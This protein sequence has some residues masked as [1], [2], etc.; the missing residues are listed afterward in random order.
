MNKLQAIVLVMMLFFAL[1]SCKTSKQ[2]AGK[3]K[4]DTTAAAKTQDTSAVKKPDVATADKQKLIDSLTPLWNKQIEYNTFA[5]KARMHYEAGGDK[6]DF[7]ANIRIQKDKIIWVSATALGGIVQVARI[8]ITPDSFKLINYLQKT[9]TLMTLQQAQALLPTPMDFGVLQ[10]LLVGNVLSKENKIIN[11]MSTPGLWTLQA[12]NA[13]FIQ[14]VTYNKA[15]TTIRSEQL[16]D[17]KPGGPQATIQYNNYV[18]VDNR[19]FSFTRAIN[20]SNAGMQYFLE[21]NYTSMDFDRAIDFPF[22]IPK[23]Y[24]LK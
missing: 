9:V 12:E 17:K 13:N 4:S 6:Q 3:K 19:M 14:E 5:G 21:M 23:N 20:M 8:Y 15:D 1:P 18:A 22:T 24:L 10:N 2:A 16:R 11:A 7:T